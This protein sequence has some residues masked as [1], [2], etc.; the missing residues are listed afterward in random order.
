M[1]AHA[2]THNAGILPDAFACLL[3]SQS[4]LAG[5]TDSCLVNKHY[6]PYNKILI[7]EY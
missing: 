7:I 6:R 3:W 4:L 2:H 5:I 1:H